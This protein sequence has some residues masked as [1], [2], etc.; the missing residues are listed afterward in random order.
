[1][2]GNHHNQFGMLSFVFSM[3]AVFVFFFYIVAIHPGIDLNENLQDP[4]VQSVEKLAEVDV[5][6]VANPWVVSPDL[7]ARGEKVYQQNCAMCHGEKGLGD[8]P[9][10]AALS[11]KAR[12][13]VEGQWTQGTGLIARYKLLVNGIPGTSMASFSHLPVNDRWSL[14]HYV[15]SITNNKGSDT[16]A[17]LEAFGQT[18]K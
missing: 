15:E 2:N 13:L 5:S 4:V 3:A 7:I 18:A 12:N 1:M 10:G 9:A 14:A 8:G 17:A 11:P 6:G 16:A